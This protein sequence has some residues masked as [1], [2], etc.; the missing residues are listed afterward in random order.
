MHFPYRDNRH[1]GRNGRKWIARLLASAAV[2]MVFGGGPGA[3]STAEAASAGTVSL[4]PATAAPGTAV[5]VTVVD[6][7]LSVM[8]TRAG[9]T[10]GPG[11][12]AHELPAGVSGT[13]YVF[14]LAFTPIADAS[15]NGQIGPEDVEVSLTSAVVANLSAGS[16]LVTLMRM[17]DNG[18]A[19]PFSVT[20]SSDQAD[21][22]TV[23][24]TS[25]ADGTG[26][27]LALAETGVA[28]GEFTATVAVGGTTSATNALSPYAT[29]RPVIG[30]ADGG[31][32]SA[33]YS[34]A[35]PLRVVSDAVLVDGT[36][37][38][39]VGLAPAHGA[40][41]R[42]VTPWAVAQ[43]TDFGSGLGL[44][45]IVF[46][47]D[48]DRDGV[49][50][51][52]GEIVGPSYEESESIRGGF[53][54]MTLLPNMGADGPTE[55]YVTAS[56][57]AGNVGRSDADALEVGDQNHLVY[58]DTNAPSLL[59]ATVGEAYD[60]D[61]EEVLTG[62]RDSVRV[63]FSEELDAGNVQAG[64]FVVDGFRATS[65]D[66]FEEFPD[67]VWL[68][69]PGLPSR[70]TLLEAAVGAVKD[71]AGQDSAP[72]QTWPVDGVPPRLQV[73]TDRVAT[74]GPVAVTVTSD[75]DLI[76]G[77]MI[78]FNNVT[79]GRA[80][81]IDLLRWVLVLDTGSLPGAVGEDGVKNVEVSAF[82]VAGNGGHGGV[83]SGEVAYPAGAT[84]FEM[85]RALGTPVITPA[86]GTTVTAHDPAIEA[87]YA[88]EAA[89]YEGDSLVAVMPILATLDD[90]DVLADLTS[91]DGAVWELETWGLG[92]GWH[93]FTIRAT[94]LAGNT[95][96]PIVV[97]F[98][99]DADIPTPTPTPTATPAPAAT[100]TPEPGGTPG[101]EAT[102]TTEATAT[103]EAVTTV[104]PVPASAV[105]AT[106]TPVTAPEPTATPVPA[107]AMAATSTPVT[108]PEP[109]ATPVPA[110][111]VAATSTPVT[112]PE[113]TATPVAEPESSVAFEPVEMPTPDGGTGL[114]ETDVAT[115][116]PAAEEWETEAEI[117]ATVQAIRAEALA[118]DLAGTKAGEGAPD[119]RP[120]NGAG[121]AGADFILYGAGL[122]G[123]LIAAGRRR[124]HT[125]PE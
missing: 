80:G 56:D 43:V 8:T 61:E 109:T 51:E 81:Q 20:Y 98:N 71:T 114:A 2:A 78:T 64:L 42:T 123:L 22:A 85:D 116:T 23:R 35:S 41:L 59:S 121:A 1:I 95:H 105:A 60:L 53:V 57:G 74:Q 83:D 92:R 94:D 28:S 91:A 115:A 122:V 30:A 48:V 5:T 70:A 33:S 11:S 101:P 46:H 17:A 63:V 24:I 3:V 103:P 118:D 100:P 120:E 37:P 31:L 117:E 52:T 38:A 107:P 55:W 67:T 69:I 27:D 19:A 84:R 73:S 87:S 54:A 113:P 82:D 49:F 14:Y 36:A 47:V 15:G 97:R 108:A 72:G 12:V 66:V 44:D 16:G 102:P 112:A 62:Q 125:V 9:E 34:D 13:T 89:E 10:T 104:T 110:P 88:G 26:F 25:D 58:V 68:T 4:V 7:D 111:A 6:P 45:S 77:P 32:V 18:S 124:V 79:V 75:E 93:T 29:T 21:L 40:G 39:V 96:G 76:V 65:A 86:Y 106:S 50:D 90:E 99:V 119:D